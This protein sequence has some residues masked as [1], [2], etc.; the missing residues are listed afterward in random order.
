MCITVFYRKEHT[1]KL[2][3]YRL[4]LQASKEVSRVPY[5]KRLAILKLGL[6]PYVG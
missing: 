5:D 1:L 3:M 2:E 6:D 4:E